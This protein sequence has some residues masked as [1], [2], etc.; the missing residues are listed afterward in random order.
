MIFLGSGAEYGIQRDVA[1]AK[2]SDFDEIVPQDEH[3][4]SKYVCSKYIENSKNIINLRLFGVFGKY[5]DYQMRFISNAICKAVYNLPITINQ[6]RVFSYLYIDD[7]ARVIEYFIKHKAREKFYNVVPGEKTELAVLAKK[8]VEVSGRKLEIT[9]KNPGMGREYTADNS[10]LL[11]EN[12]G[13]KFTPMNEA[14][15]EL[16]K[17]YENRKPEIDYKLLLVDP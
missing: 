5:E 7:L 10:R 15:T 2:E 17:W 9:V 8:V 4:F 12:R 1:C 14:I 3:G 16:Y 13:I 6:N 11:R